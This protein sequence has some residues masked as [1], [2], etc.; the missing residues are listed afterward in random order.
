MHY[1]EKRIYFFERDLCD[2]IVRMFKDK[3]VFN[4]KTTFFLH[5]FFWAAFFVYFQ[6]SSI[7][8]GDA[9]DLVTAAYLRGVAH[10]PGYPLYTFI[11][12]L[13]TKL[14]FNTVAWRVGLLSS[15]PS[16]ATLTMLYLLLRMV[17]KKTILSL[18]TV[19]TLGF[20][21]LFWLYA[22]VP[23]V[24]ALH[25]FFV[26]T[27][28]YL[29]FLWSG[30]RNQR[31]LFLFVFVFGLSLTH[32]HIILLMIPA[33]GYWLYRHKKLLPRFSFISISKLIGLFIFGL[34]PYTYVYFAA[35]SQPPINWENPVT[36]Q[37][38]FRLVTRAEYGTF[39][40]QVS[41]PHDTVTVLGRVT[42]IASYVNIVKQDF[43]IIGLL[44]II[45][46]AFYQWKTKKDQFWFTFLTVFFTGPV[47]IVYAA[48]PLEKIY[49]VGV[50]ER[51]LLASYV[52][53]A[54]WLLYGLEIVTKNILSLLKGLKLTHVEYYGKLIYLFLF[55]LPLLVLYIN[56]PKLSILKNDRTTE[57]FAQDIL[58]TVPEGSIVIPVGDTMSF[59]V[60]HMHYV[61][62]YRP[63]VILFHLFRAG[64]P[65]YHD[66][67]KKEYPQLDLPDADEV[68]DRDFLSRF[69]EK[70]YDT[71]P[72][73]TFGYYD[74]SLEGEWV[75]Q[76]LLT[77]FYKKDDM[78]SEDFIR[79]E[80]TRLW[81]MYHD[82]LSGSLGVYR[83]QNMILADVLTYYIIAHRN[84]GKQFYQ[85]GWYTNAE[86][87]FQ[88]AIK[89]N[90]QYS[91]SFYWLA[92]TQL[93]QKKC[94]DA[95]ERTKQAISLYD[96]NYRYYLLLA[97][98][99]E[100][101]L[102]NDEKAVELKNRAE[103]LKKKDEVLLERL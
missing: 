101:C 2:R 43:L 40:L 6:T 80:N 41:V 85:N 27:L 37:Q 57:Y 38:F 92:H 7:Y 83:N 55:I 69:I 88:E 12:H 15:I 42:Q 78:P 66:V 100:T 97:E 95:R 10:P 54:V 44:L 74:V 36:L 34:I 56:Y 47:F 13:L 26:V 46:G 87:H 39:Q 89:L 19:S 1:T 103:E 22:I 24:F 94:D 3:R 35:L 102:H 5:F 4:S 17:S 72:I 50:F 16:A 20:T 14:P 90:R 30:T 45:T 25:T 32:H 28:T 62:R 81:D 75:Q 76:G 99:Y 33:F 71:A 11:G 23:E 86:N 91:D 51:F 68:T 79:S 61:Y 73:Y 65:I 77:R 59:D 82:P 9:G 67:I 31:Y 58:D 48:F 53:L 63:D 93:K 29:L 98:I 18:V 49:E 8:G 70:N 21:Y 60:Q 64:N 84:T 52:F 96:T